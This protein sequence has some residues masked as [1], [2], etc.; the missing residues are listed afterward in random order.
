MENQK[1]KCS[2]KKHQEIDAIS[3]CQKCKKYFCNKCQNLHSELMDE[4]KIINLEQ[5]NDVFIDL[6]KEANHNAKLEYFCKEH[7]TLCC[8]ACTSKRK[9]EGYGQH[10]DCD[11]C[12][13]KNIEQEKKNKLK[14][15]IKNLEEIEILKI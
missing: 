8:V 12:P 14:E 5:K 6:C 2:L 1:P 11:V 4:H 15:N 9:D 3:Y 7:N 10:F 13:I